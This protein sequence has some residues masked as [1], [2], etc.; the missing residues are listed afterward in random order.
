MVEWSAGRRIR[1]YSK[2]VKSSNTL[3]RHALLKL[4]GR[5]ENHRKK[6]RKTN[7]N[8]DPVEL[9]PSVTN[10]CARAQ[11]LANVWDLA[12]C[13]LS[14]VFLTQLTAAPRSSLQSFPL[15]LPFASFIDPI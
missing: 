12:S 8:R 11:K 6:K 14:A 3:G 7:T 4:V 9:F 10:I 5:K 15:S 1:R 2:N 13:I